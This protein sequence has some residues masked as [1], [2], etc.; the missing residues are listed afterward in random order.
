MYVFEGWSC[1]SSLRAARGVWR[2]PVCFLAE[3]FPVTG[4]AFDDE[5]S[6][7]F[8]MALLAGFCSSESEFWRVSEDFDDSEDLSSFFLLSEDSLSEESS[9]EDEE[10]DEESLELEPDSGKGVL[11]AVFRVFLSAFLAELF[12]EDEESEELESDESDE[13]ESVLESE[14]EESEES[15][16]ESE[17]ESESDESEEEEEELL[18]LSDD[19]ESEESED[20]SF[21][22][23]AL[24]ASFS[25]SEELESNSEELDSALRFMPV[26]LG[27]AAGTSSSSSAS[28]SELE[29]EEEG[30]EDDEREDCL[31]C[32][33]PISTSESLDSSELLSLS[34][35]ELELELELEDSSDFLVQLWKSSSKDGAFS[36]SV[37]AID[38]SACSFARAL[39]VLSKPFSDRNV[40][41]EAINCGGG[42]SIDRGLSVPTTHY[43]SST[44]AFRK[45]LPFW[46][47][48]TSSEPKL[49]CPCALPWSSILLEIAVFLFGVLV[50]IEKKKKKLEGASKSGLWIMS[51]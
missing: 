5:V 38:L 21:A 23:L 49:S 46:Y 50:K 20:S 12:S 41:I 15:E 13:S 30:E 26:D 34:L 16:S 28:L 36:E 19:E 44:N 51:F 32:A 4:L 24:G 27:P 7:A 35:E 10:P 42:G 9:S 11:I 17:P 22:F 39:L 8:S 48:E 3:L 40:A 45:D 29:E 18:S 37:W 1:G 47:W 33:S 2:A 31:D 6:R 14:S 43:S 25:D